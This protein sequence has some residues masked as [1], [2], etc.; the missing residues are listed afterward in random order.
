L[1]I[2]LSGIGGGSSLA[3]SGPRRISVVATGAVCQDPAVIAVQELTPD[4]WAL[5]RA[6]RIEATTTEPEAFGST[7]AE[8]VETTEAQWR[9]RLSKPSLHLV[10]RR[11]GDAVGMAAVNHEFE[12]GSVWV[13][14][15]ARGSGTGHR[16][17]EAALRWAASRKAPLVRLAVRETNAAAIGLYRAHGFIEVGDDYLNPERVH[18]LILMAY[19][20]M[21]QSDLDRSCDVEP[22][23]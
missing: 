13:R 12:L 8:V 22:G 7:L 3:A 2:L 9:A 21:P 4:D 6:L 5:W 17:V 23:R 1:P 14:P 19:G 11:G 16:L 18:R 20:R 15:N 10:A